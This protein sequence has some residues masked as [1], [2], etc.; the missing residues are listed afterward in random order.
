MNKKG[1]SY[2]RKDGRWECRVF[3]KKDKNG[4]RKFRSF[5]GKTREEAEYKMLLEQQGT[6][7]DYALTEMTVKELGIEWLRVMSARLKESTESN[8]RMKLDKHIFPEFGDM[9]CCLMNTKNVYI[10]IEKKLNSGLSPR[11]VADIIV[12]LK[13]LFRYASREYHIRNI[14]DGIVMPKK[15]KPDISI[16]TQEQQKDLESYIAENQSL[17]T[18]GISL[19]MYMGLRIG[20]LCALQWNDVDLKKRTLTVRK[21]IQR[22]QNFDGNS[23]TKLVV[24]EPKSAGSMRE[25]P[26]PDC[27]IPFL[28]A[29]QSRK[30]SYILSGNQKPVEPRALQYRFQK[31][32]KNAELPS[33]HYHSLRHLFATNC[34]ALGFD[35]K[36]LSEILGHSS[37]EVT[38]NRYVHTSM[39]RKRMCMNLISKSA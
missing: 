11:Y 2:L 4:K 15:S 21:T 12:L 30:N 17:T 33:V 35:V 18:L 28:K 31:I 25:I 23:K 26:V 36:T 13:S 6:A 1:N 20:E 16:L 10:F 19:S 14:L 22:I 3:V 37:V 39:D 8:Y 29:F 24:T 32:L 9:Q 7:Q 38:L 34:I 27:L 5:Y